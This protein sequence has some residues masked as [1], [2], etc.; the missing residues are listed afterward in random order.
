MLLVDI[1]K[2]ADESTSPKSTLK[3]NIADSAPSL[4]QGRVHSS[5]TSSGF[6]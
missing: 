3:E 5:D 4:F 6:D 1:H 2:R